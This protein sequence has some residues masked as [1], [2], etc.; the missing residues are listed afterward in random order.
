MNEAAVK[1]A[2]G[3]AIFIHAMPACAGQTHCDDNEVIYF[4]C[5]I[6]NKI[7]S[8]C[9]SKNLSENSGYL[10]YRY[11]KKEHIELS[12]PSSLRHPTNLFDFEMGGNSGDTE[13]AVTFNNEQYEYRLYNIFSMPPP[14]GE[15]LGDS[16][17]HAGLHLSKAGKYI[18]TM[19][20][21]DETY[22][23]TLNRLPA[24]LFKKRF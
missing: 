6:K 24:F 13:V 1:F 7:M 16:G 11:G 4:N 5:E 20:C 17:E 14:D 8:L 18:K 10:Q 9:G 3:F 2:L 22:V 12:Y 21:D 19:K 15:K 23:F